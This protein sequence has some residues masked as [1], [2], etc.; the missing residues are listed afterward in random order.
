MKDRILKVMEREA[1]TPARFSEAI[2][3]QRSA[4]SHIVSGRN[5]PSLDVL[6]K[7]LS[8]YTHI[9]TDWL[10]KGE[11]P[12]YKTENNNYQPSLFTENDEIRPEIRVV[13]E[14]SQQ[15]I[16]ELPKSVAKP[17]EIEQVVYEERSSKNV[18]KIMIFY[19]DN[20]FETFTPEKNKTE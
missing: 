19:S 4:M 3:I 15:M 17:T 12:M 7:I 16:V 13:S 18:S 11:G 9:S 6:M 2:G 8:T 1:L 20:T 10:L 5:N 14:K